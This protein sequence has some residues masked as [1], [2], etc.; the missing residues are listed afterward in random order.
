MPNC[1]GL[2]ILSTTSPYFY[3]SCSVDLFFQGCGYRIGYH[4][5]TGTDVLGGHLHLGRHKRRIL[6]N[7]QNQ[8]A[9][10]SGQN[11]DQG[12]GHGKNG[13]LDKK[14]HAVLLFSGWKK[15]TPNIELSTSSF[16]IGYR[17][18]HRS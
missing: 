13:S 12:N 5:G 2:Y 8:H 9:N 11:H 10:G 15:L 6:G 3:A 1:L 4:I 16:Q 17:F 18:V 14:V 7:G